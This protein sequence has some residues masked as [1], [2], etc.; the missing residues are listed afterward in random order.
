MTEAAKDAFYAK[1]STKEA[2]NKAIVR[3]GVRAYE[4]IMRNFPALKKLNDLVAAKASRGYLKGL[5]GRQMPIRSKHAAL[6]TLL[7]GGGAVVM[8]KALVL[9]DQNMAKAGFTM[10]V[11][12]ALLANVHDEFQVECRPDIAQQVGEIAAEA[13]R[14]AGIALD[15]KCP[16]AGSFDI[17]R[18]WK[19]TH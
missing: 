19:E 16:L 5:D 12:F 9:F 11:D 14:L 1:F 6:N 2:L 17:G 13:I 8:K 7:Q 18:N 4:N 10:D 15:L 3:L